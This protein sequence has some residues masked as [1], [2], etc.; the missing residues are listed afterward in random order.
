MRTGL[1][2]LFLIHRPGFAMRF[3]PTHVS[4]R[5]WLDPRYH[6]DFDEEHFLRAYLRPGDTVVDA[7]ANIGFTTLVAASTVGPTG[8]V[9]AI[10]PHPRIFSYLRGNVRLNRADVELHNLALGE[11]SGRLHLS[12]EEDEC[13]NAVRQDERGLPVAVRRL[14]DIADAVGPV[15]LLKLDVE[16]YELFALRGSAKTLEG[17]ECLYVESFE[18]NFRRYGYTGADMLGLLYDVG[19]RVFRQVDTG[20]LV[21]VARSHNSKECENLIAVRNLPELLERTSL[22]LREAG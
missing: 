1:S 22:R 14:D 20:S 21:S 16:G 8:T 4:A 13:V 7:G 15:R 3:Y 9:I 2:R 12:D 11:E 5:L 18:E 6:G 17:V 10:E 19:F